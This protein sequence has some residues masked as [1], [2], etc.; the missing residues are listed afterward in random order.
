M[1]SREENPDGIRCISDSL[2]VAHSAVNIAKLPERLRRSLPPRHKTTRPPTEAA[3][4]RK[5]MEWFNRKTSI[6]GIQISNWM[7]V[8]GA[9]LV[10]LLIYNS[11]H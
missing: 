10:I 8:L 7:I 2:T 9:V 5:A 6:A 4:G 1:P 3:Y 11:M